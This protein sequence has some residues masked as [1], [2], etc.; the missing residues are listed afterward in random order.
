MVFREFVGM[1]KIWPPITK[2][3]PEPQ[4]LNRQSYEGLR[5]PHECPEVFTITSEFEHFLYRV[6]ICRL[7]CNG[8]TL[9]LT[10]A[11]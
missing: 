3:K 1:P 8:V 2:L 9:A 5:Y 4:K 11:S 7:F 10:N 6:S